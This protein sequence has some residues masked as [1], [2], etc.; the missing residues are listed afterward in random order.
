V[1]LQLGAAETQLVWTE[2]ARAIVRAWRAWANPDGSLYAPQALL[3]LACDLLPGESVA[4]DALRRPEVWPR[5]S[6][7]L[8]DEQERRRQG[9]QATGVG[10]FVYGVELSAEGY[11]RNE[12]TLRVGERHVMMVWNDEQLG[13]A[14]VM[15]RTL[16]SFI[17]EREVGPAFDRANISDRWHGMP[18][19]NVLVQYSSL[20]D[21]DWRSELG[22]SAIVIWVANSVLNEMDHLKFY[23]ETAR[24]RDRARTFVRWIDQ[25]LSQAQ[26]PQGMRMQEGVYLRVAPTRSRSGM[27]DTDHIEAAADLR[28]R[29]VPVNLITADVG[30]RSRAAV[31]GIPV[32]A[33]ADRWK[34]A[35]EPSPREKEAE[36]RMRAAGLSAPPILRLST[37]ERPAAALLSVENGEAGG[38]ARGVVVVWRVLG[39]NDIYVSNRLE[40][41]I[42]GRLFSNDVNGNIRQQL[43]SVLSPGTQELLAE[44][45]FSQSPERIDYEIRAEGNLPTRAELVFG[46]HEAE[47]QA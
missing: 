15:G 43:T 11:A 37:Q 21:I 9:E 3:A 25:V 45:G 10:V 4:G 17:R 22:Q 1:N 47:V 12:G 28:D 18:D 27:R 44:I 29:G 30:A 24:V 42:G 32:R 38:E 33:L 36:A 35:D 6:T 46:N 34:L 31:N 8:Y 16:R 2:G 13:S 7:A 5:L 40:G 19:T 23:G 26:T 14:G 20:R 39:G 41:Q